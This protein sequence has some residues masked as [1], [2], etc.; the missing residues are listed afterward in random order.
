[1]IAAREA[2]I[3]EMDKP[4]PAQVFATAPDP[5]VTPIWMKVPTSHDFPVD[6]WT[7]PSVA[8]KGKESSLGS[9]EIA[10]AEKMLETFTLPD[11]YKIELIERK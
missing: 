5:T 1:M 11:G 6:T 3:W 8:E 7:P 2:A 9:I 10:D 4:T